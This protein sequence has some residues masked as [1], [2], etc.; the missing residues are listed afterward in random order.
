VAVAVA[1]AVDVV[2]VSPSS[3]QPPMVSNPASVTG[4]GG[5]V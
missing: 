3:L 2:V 1:V 4:S 5:G